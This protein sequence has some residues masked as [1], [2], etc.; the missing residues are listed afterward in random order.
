MPQSP[1]G[2]DLKSMRNNSSYSIR[3]I[4]WALA[5]GAAAGA[6]AS[7]ANGHW[8]SSESRYSVDVTVGSQQQSY[9]V[10]SVFWTPPF[11]RDG[12]NLGVGHDSAGGGIEQDFGD[13]FSLN[14]SFPSLTRPTFTTQTYQPAEVKI[15]TFVEHRF[16]LDK[17]YRIY[18]LTGFGV[19]SISGNQNVTVS[20]FGSAKLIRV[21]DGAVILNRDT[22][23]LGQGSRYFDIPGTNAGVY[24]LQL[25]ANGV[26]Q[27][28]AGNGHT[29][30]EMTTRGDVILLNP[31]PEP[32]TMAAL[33][34]G[35]GCLLRRRTRKP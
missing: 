11:L 22:A 23:T 25:T 14:N 19:S 5:L 35:M 13:Q 1:S 28:P 29:H 16:Y 4:R 27:A 20:F 15:D 7:R 21:S 32:A 10:G 6:A 24:A 2:Y 30:V 9:S 33:A 17:S 3:A 18:G 31:V 26:L 8:I 12:F 34:T